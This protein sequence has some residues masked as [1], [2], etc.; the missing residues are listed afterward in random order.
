MVTECS[1]HT[2]RNGK[3]KIDKTSN[4]NKK[5]SIDIPGFMKDPERNKSEKR[6]KLRKGKSSEHKGL[7]KIE[8]Q[9]TF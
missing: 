4:T 9:A 6:T 5:M 3:S 8:Q 7:E 1:I 2:L